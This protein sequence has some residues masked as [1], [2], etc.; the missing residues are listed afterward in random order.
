MCKSRSLFISMSEKRGVKG[1][2]YGV[3]GGAVTSVRELVRIGCIREAVL[4]VLQD[5][6]LE[7]F[8]H[9][10]R[11]SNEPKVIEVAVVRCFGNMY[12]NS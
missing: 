9:H 10:R 3:L 2:G 1:D 6:P 5:Q 4:D 8:Y 7:A 12:N 11:E